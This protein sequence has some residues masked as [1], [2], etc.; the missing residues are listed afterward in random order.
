MHKLSVIL[1]RSCWKVTLSFCRGN[2]TIS[3]N[4]GMINR[5]SFLKFIII[6]S[7]RS[8]FIIQL[9]GL[10]LYRMIDY[11]LLQDNRVEMEYGRGYNWKKKNS[12][13]FASYGN[14]T[15]E[16]AIFEIWFDFIQNISI[17]LLNLEI[18][19]ET[20]SYSSSLF[21]FSISPVYIEI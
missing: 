14:V 1:H 17:L 11:Q 12:W 7:R 10:L 5:N 16:G 8:I 18:Q 13:N 15:S 6:T 2:Q 3:Y 21:I 9:L 4:N 20:V 19:E